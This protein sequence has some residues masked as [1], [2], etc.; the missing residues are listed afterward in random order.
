MR[1]DS[2]GLTDPLPPAF[3]LEMHPA[4]GGAKGEKARG[5][6]GTPLWV[7]TPPAPP[8][9]DAG[10]TEGG[11]DLRECWVTAQQHCFFRTRF[12]DWEV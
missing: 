8:T 7:L 4:S 11:A 3:S 1:E 12:P 9:C 10:L 2:E 6:T 5:R